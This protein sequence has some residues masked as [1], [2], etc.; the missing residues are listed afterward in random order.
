MSYSQE[1]TNEESSIMG[2]L[3]NDS[4]STYDSHEEDQEEN[5][6]E[7][8]QEEAI[9]RHQEEWQA[10]MEKYKHSGDSVEVA[11]A[12]ASNALVPTYRKELR[13]VFFE[14]LKWMHYMKKDPS[15]KKV[16]ETRKNLMNSED[17][18]WDE[19]TESAINQRKFLLNKMFSKQEVPKQTTINYP[20]FN[21]YAH[22]Y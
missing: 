12:K 19:A 21:P 5:V 9:N 18:S 13:E 2:S 16:M 22:R 10:L 15:Y 20:T 11:E 6:W 14:H 4:E 8:L 17:Y 3:S 1:T 7:R